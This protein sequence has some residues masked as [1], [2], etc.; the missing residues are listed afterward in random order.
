MADDDPD[1]FRAR[2]PWTGV[3]AK[4]VAAWMIVA[5]R[6]FG[7]EIVP[8][9]EAGTIDEQIARATDNVRR[10]IAIACARR[11]HDAVLEKSRVAVESSET[12]CV[13]VALSAD[14][15]E[16]RYARHRAAPN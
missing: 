8:V 15:L 16:A 4:I 7:G 1:F 6:R 9:A 13:A 14:E 11:P 5:E 10:R 3:T 2:C 12:F